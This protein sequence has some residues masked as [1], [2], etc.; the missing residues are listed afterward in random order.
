MAVCRVPT[1]RKGTRPVEATVKVNSAVSTRLNSKM[2]RHT[3]DSAL[4]CNY[5][6]RIMRRDRMM[7]ANTEIIREWVAYIQFAVLPCQALVRAGLELGRKR[8]GRQV[9]GGNSEGIQLPGFGQTRS[10]HCKLVEFIRSRCLPLGT[11][12]TGPSEP[13][14]LANLAANAGV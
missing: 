11:Q 7:N 13:R 6:L 14:P 2:P 5:A 3:R 4:K 8:K 9:I 12:Q 1:A 10:P